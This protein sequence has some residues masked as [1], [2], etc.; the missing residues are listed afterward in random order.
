MGGVVF[1]Q[2]ILWSVRKGVVLEIIKT[3]KCPSVLEVLI[4]RYTSLCFV[5]FKL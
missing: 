1:V 2:Q 4:M 5:T 3:D